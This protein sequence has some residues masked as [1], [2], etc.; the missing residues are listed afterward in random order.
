MGFWISLLLIIVTP[1][2]SDVFR[3][4]MLPK[5]DKNQ[6]YLWV[7]AERNKTISGTLAIAKDIE[8]F[9]MNYSGTGTNNEFIPENLRIISN[10]DTSIGDRFLPDFANLFR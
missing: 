1:I 3:A 6:V 7:D 9:L 5:A 2:M 8:S 4:R 10:L